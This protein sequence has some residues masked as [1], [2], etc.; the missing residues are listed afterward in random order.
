MRT[1]TGS[2][3]VVSLPG[4]GPSLPWA[5]TAP[6]GSLLLVYRHH[7]PAHKLVVKDW[8][9]VHESVPEIHW[10]RVHEPFD[11]DFTFPVGESGVVRELTHEMYLAM[12]QAPSV[13]SYLAMMPLKCVS[14]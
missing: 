3:I 8:V 1:L 6:R 10:E 7:V 11:E 13:S 2:F 5:T 12:I 4:V 9:F 14:P